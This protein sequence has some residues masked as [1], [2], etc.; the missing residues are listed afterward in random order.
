MKVFEIVRTH[1]TRLKLNGAF[2]NRGLPEYREKK[3]IV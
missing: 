3:L 2:H 1:V